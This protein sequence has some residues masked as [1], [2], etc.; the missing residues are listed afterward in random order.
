MH[1][2]FVNVEEGRTTVPLVLRESVQALS[3]VGTMDP[4]ALFLRDGSPSPQSLL[5]VT[6]RGYFLLAVLGRGDEPSVHAMRQLSAATSE[7][8]AWGRPLIALGPAFGPTPENTVFGTDIDGKIAAMLAAGARE[9]SIRLPLVAMCDSFG[10]I[11]YLSRGYNTSLASD[12]RR[13][14]PSISAE[15]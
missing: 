7:L 12:L 8:E 11:V 5:S 1:L 2:E 14:I 13:I 4:E 10:H 9:E 3:V 6:G 15:R